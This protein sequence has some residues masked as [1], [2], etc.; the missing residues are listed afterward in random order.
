M[1]LLVSNIMAWDGEC[2]SQTPEYLGVAM[3][4]EELRIVLQNCDMSPQGVRCSILVQ[5]KCQEC[6]GVICWAQT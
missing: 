4:Y 5:D 3:I 2:G 1:F 6:R